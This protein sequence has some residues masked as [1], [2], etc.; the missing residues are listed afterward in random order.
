MCPIESGKTT[1]DRPANNGC[2]ACEDRS[3]NISLTDDELRILY[4]DNPTE[5]GPWPVE[6]PEESTHWHGKYEARKSA[7]K[8]IEQAYRIRNGLS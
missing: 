8:K 4:F 2:E 1:P 3:H 5:D 7:R 6:W